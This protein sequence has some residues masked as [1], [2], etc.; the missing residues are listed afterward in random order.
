M[1]CRYKPSLNLIDWNEY[2][3]EMVKSQGGEWIPYRTFIDE[4]ARLTAMLRR[5]GERL[6]ALQAQVKQHMEGLC[7]QP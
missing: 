7:Q 3:V 4:Q 6:Q 1:V 5:Q 2:G